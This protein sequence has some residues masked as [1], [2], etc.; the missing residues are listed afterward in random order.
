MHLNQSCRKFHEMHKSNK[1]KIHCLAGGWGGDVKICTSTK[2]AGNFMKSINPLKKLFHCL[3]N[4]EIFKSK[5]QEYMKE[6]I[7]IY[8]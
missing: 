7:R 3:A 2:I 4:G 1:N 6:N 5:S 8:S